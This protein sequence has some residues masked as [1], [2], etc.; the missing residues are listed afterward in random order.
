M[1]AMMTAISPA[2]FISYLPRPGPGL[3]LR[4]RPLS[5]A[6]DPPTSHRPPRPLPKAPPRPGGGGRDSLPAVLGY[7]DRAE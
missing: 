4:P 2:L 7:N 3:P 1:M 5:H 6:R